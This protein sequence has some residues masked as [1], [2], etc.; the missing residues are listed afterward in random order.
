[1]PRPVF[2]SGVDVS[3]L[4]EIEDNGGKYYDKGVQLD[5]LQIF[6]RYGVNTIRLRIWHTPRYGY[7]DLEH[8]L[9]MAKRVKTLGLGLMLDIHYSDTWAD[10]AHQAK[11]A[12]WKDLS[13]EDL[14]VA[15]HDYT[16]YVIQALKLQGTL[17]D[18]VQIG[19][20]ITPGFL[21]PEGAVGGKDEANWPRFAGLLKAAIAGVSDSL[22]P[23]ERV[24]IILHIDAGGN[25]RVAR[26][27]FDNIQTQGV[28]FDIIGLSFYPWWHGTLDDLKVNIADLTARYDKQLWV[29]ETAYP[30]VMEGYINS[31]LMGDPSKLVPGYPASVEGQRDFLLAEWGVIKAAGGSGMIYWE[32]DILPVP[33]AASGW[34]NLGMFDR[35]GKALESLSAFGGK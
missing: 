5:A 32:P 15:V 11:P 20:E 23:G 9:Q 12:A 35:E 17:P 2:T 19:N 27:F 31:S 10:P 33:I 16:R 22:L 4:Q 18:S 6:K 8:V 25:N 13:Y 29:V 14:K 34:G 1:M 3:W 30:H 28:P 7:N 26:W 21:W 24:D